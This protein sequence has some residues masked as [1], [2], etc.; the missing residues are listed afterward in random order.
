MASTSVMEDVVVL[1]VAMVAFFL[2]DFEVQIRARSASERAQR[3]YLLA[4][5]VWR[6]VVLVLTRLG[7]LAGKVILGDCRA[8]NQSLRSRHISF[9]HHH[10]I[11]A[12]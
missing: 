10:H 9:L 7:F 12:K 2:Q 1:V 6:E 8:H 4:G 5:E 3:K 11:K